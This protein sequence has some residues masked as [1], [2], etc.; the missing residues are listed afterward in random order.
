MKNMVKSGFSRM[1]TVLMV[2][3]VTSVIGGLIVFTYIRRAVTLAKQAEID[4]QMMAYAQANWTEIMN[5]NEFKRAILA[6]RENEGI[7]CMESSAALFKKYEQDMAQTEQK[8][9]R[10]KQ[11]IMALEQKLNK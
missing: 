8:I 9:E 7:L 6:C 2:A 10:N 1:L 11:E 5:N 3:A 4:N